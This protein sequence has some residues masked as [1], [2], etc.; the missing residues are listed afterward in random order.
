MADGELFK[1]VSDNL[2]AFELDIFV[3]HYTYED[4]HKAL[5]ERINFLLTANL[6][7]VLSSLYRLDV[8]EKKLKEALAN[9]TGT[10]ASDL[11]ATMIIERQLEKIASRKT[12]RTDTSIP[13]DE[14]W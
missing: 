7:L 4:L 5:S 13:E 9:E 2:N 6:P 1:Q 12:F 11:M 3:A 14:K 10:P 8:S